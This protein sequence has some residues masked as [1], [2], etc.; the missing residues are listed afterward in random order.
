TEGKKNRCVSLCFTSSLC[1]STDYTKCCYTKV[2]QRRSDSLLGK[3]TRRICSRRSA[4]LGTSQLSTWIRSTY[5]GSRKVSYYERPA[6]L[7]T[8]EVPALRC[9]VQET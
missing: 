8:K 6:Y 9:A 3:K 1:Y 2:C 4:Y 7:A 5:L